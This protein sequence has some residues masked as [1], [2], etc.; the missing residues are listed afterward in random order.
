MKYLGD[1]CDHRLVFFSKFIAEYLL[2]V[3]GKK[4]KFVPTSQRITNEK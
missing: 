2:F 4:A 1:M 3:P